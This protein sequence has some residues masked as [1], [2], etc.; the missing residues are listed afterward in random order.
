[1]ERYRGEIFQLYN[2]Q[3]KPLHEVLAWLNERYGVDVT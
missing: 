2:A 1:M 3:N